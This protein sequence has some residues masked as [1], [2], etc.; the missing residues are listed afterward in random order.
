MST[1]I[2]TA[3]SNL[4]PSSTE[5]RFSETHENVGMGNGFDTFTGEWANGQRLSVINHVDGTVTIRIGAGGQGPKVR[6]SRQAA[7]KLAKTITEPN[8]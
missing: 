5:S 8:F 6:L 2:N 1:E 3:E 4:I 7:Y